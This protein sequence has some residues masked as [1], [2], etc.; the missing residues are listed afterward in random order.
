[1]SRPT[2]RLSARQVAS[3]K[4]PG[5]HADGQGL[6]L[7]VEAPKNEGDAPNRRWSFIFRWRGKRSEMGLGALADISLARARELRTEKRDL[8]SRGV[9]PIKERRRRREGGVTFGVFADALFAELEG[10][11]KNAKHREQWKTS[12]E[13]HA[14]PLRALELAE[15]DTE[16]VLGVLRPIWTRIPETA[17]R[18]R[19]RIERVL[20]AA[21]AAGHRAETSENPARWRGH[22]KSLLPAPT[23]GKRH[24]PAMPWAAVPAFAATLREQDDLA[25]YALELTILTVL[26]TG[27]TLGAQW[28]EFDMTAKVWTVPGERMKMGKPHRVPLSDASIAV[29]EKAGR[30]LKRRKADYVFPG[31]RANPHL[32]DM[33]MTMVLRRLGGGAYTVHG[34]RSSFRD[35]A[36]DATS[37]PREIAEAA[38]AHLVGTDVER[39][40]RRADALDKRRELMVA[41]ADFLA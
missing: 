40:Y 33:S 12:L 25:A 35:W 36:G 22:L 32:S 15:I 37:F 34:F 2:N 8:V 30:G 17:S 18:T 7:V 28:G 4:K 10:G 3:E 23:K 21:K 39:A 20:D 27:E 31:Q 24:H 26:R 13:V 29:L 11:W 38:L 14:A 1:M 41:W 16:D 5:Y 6:Y 9:N 19:N